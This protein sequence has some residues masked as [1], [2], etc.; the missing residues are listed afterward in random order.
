M[1]DQVKLKHKKMNEK[2]ILYTNDSMI[3]AYIKEIRITF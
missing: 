1:R 3:F 2:C